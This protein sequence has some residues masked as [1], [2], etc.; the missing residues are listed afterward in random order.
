M[1]HYVKY[2]TFISTIFLS[3][4]T[5]MTSLIESSGRAVTTWF[6]SVATRAVAY[7]LSQGERK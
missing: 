2:R 4:G 3:A 6:R 7:I 1:N 5:R